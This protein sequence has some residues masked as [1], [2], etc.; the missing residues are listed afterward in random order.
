LT[1]SVSNLVGNY[2]TY[3]GQWRTL[4][5]VKT[6]NQW[7]DFLRWDE[8]PDKVLKS[9]FDWLD[10]PAGWSFLKYKGNYYILGDFMRFKFMDGDSNLT[11]W[12]AYHQ[13]S[14]WGGIVIA[15]SDDGEQYRI[16]RYAG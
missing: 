13:D 8:V 15:I 6:N 10:D 16:G 1:L 11:G 3:L 9:D 5:K 7:R 2:A 4:V 14:A 12:H